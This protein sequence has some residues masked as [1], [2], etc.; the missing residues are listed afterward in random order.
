MASAGCAFSYLL[1]EVHL[2]VW[3]P[4]CYLERLSQPRGEQVLVLTPRSTVEAIRAALVVTDLV[5]ESTLSH[6][7]TPIRTTAVTNRLSTTSRDSE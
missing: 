4:G 1:W 2:L 3:S 5:G 6:A 7:A